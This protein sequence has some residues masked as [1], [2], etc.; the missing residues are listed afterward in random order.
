MG[1]FRQFPYTNFHELNLDWI[2]NTVKDLA[3][4]WDDFT[5]NWG[6]KV[7]DEVDKWL[8][9][10][11]EATT[12]V[13]DHSISEIKLTEE[14]AAKT[15]KDYY[16]PQ[17]FGAV[18]DGVTD[19]TDAFVEL[20]GYKPVAI[21]EGN[22]VINDLVTLE[23][24][25]FDFGEYTNFMP[26]YE[27]SVDLDLS[28]V[29]YGPNIVLPIKNSYCE[30]GVRMGNY[31]YL[32]CRNVV[33]DVPYVAIIDTDNTVITYKNL[34]NVYGNANSMHTDGTYIY[35]D[36][37]TG[38]H[39]VMDGNLD[40]EVSIY[41]TTYENII[42]YNKTWYA[43]NFYTDHILLYQLNGYNGGVV[44]SWNITVPY[45]SHQSVT[46]IDGVLYIPTV[47]AD[48]N[49]HVNWFRFVDIATH[50]LI[51]QINYNSEQ[52]IE[53][54]FIDSDNTIKAVGHYYGLQGIA[55]II[56]FDGVDY[57]TMKYVHIYGDEVEPTTNIVMSQRYN[58][59][60]ISQGDSLTNIPFN[61][62]DLL[63]LENARLAYSVTENKIA[64]YHDNAWHLLSAIS[65]TEHS[66]EL[67]IDGQT[68]T[69]RN[70]ISGSNAYLNIDTGGGSTWATLS[71]GAKIGELDPE[72]IPRFSV[73]VPGLVR[74]VGA[75]NLANFFPCNLYLYTN[76]DIKIYGNESQLRQCKYIQCYA[77]YPINRDL[78]Y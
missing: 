69:A 78:T 5:A 67:T 55:N 56:T 13:L 40:D 4:K 20:S 15:I 6:E 14:L 2:I 50:K 34:S 58:F 31:Y 59:W 45:A 43:V 29:T 22:Y 52:E 46:I 36:F 70:G 9:D 53:S 8:D 44:Y 38:Y 61:T 63:I 21:P 73:N 30:A 66:I 12:T 60:R 7:A 71:N 72:V 16:T 75:Q 28:S 49:I 18:G 41:N 74:D 76:G 17:M 3:A 42:P 11:P 51:K 54:F 26:L 33:G 48:P 23:D 37:D 24:V 47:V 1:I 65:P 35:I 27:K 19:D 68:Y 62:C 10:H 39:V 77:M 32:V 25:L 64:E 57:P